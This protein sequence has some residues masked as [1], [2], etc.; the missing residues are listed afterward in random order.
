MT[1]AVCTTLA[2]FCCDRPETSEAW[3]FN[4]EAM[5][6]ASDVPVEFFAA[7]EVDARGLE[8]FAGVLEALSRVGGQFW[9]YTLDDGRTEIHTNNRLRHITM[10]QNLAVDY[11]TT[12]GASHMLFLAA[13]LEPP[14][15][16][17]PKLLD[18][19]WPIVGGECTTYCLSG[20]KVDSHPETGQRFGFPVERH[21]ATAAFVMV[22][23][24]LFKRLRWRWDA[25]TGESDDPCYHRDAIELFEIETLIRKDVVGRHHPE[26]VGPIETRYPGR[27]MQVWR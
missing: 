18:M 6:E 1:V 15:D 8:P 23:R 21:M 27:D 26:A 14:T 10:G 11:A 20:P 22:R 4:A 17:V 2:A 24:D 5:R 7:L 25:D 12:I 13:D 3:L 19:H 16:A 9:T